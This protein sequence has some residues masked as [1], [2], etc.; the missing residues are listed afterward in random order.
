MEQNTIQQNEVPA[1]PAPMSDYRQP[2]S[3]N[4]TKWIVVFIVLLILGGAGIFFFAQSENESQATPTPSFNVLPIDNE[5]LEDPT[6]TPTPASVDKSEISIEIQNGTGIPGEAAFLQ[7]ELKKLGYSDIEAGN[8][9]STDY[10][11]TVVTFSKSVPEQVQTSLKQELEKI[12]KSVT[13][14]T[15][16]SQTSSVLIITGPRKATSSSTPKATSS[17]TPKATSSAT[18]KA[19]SSATPN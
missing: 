16:S 7:T 13:V 19:T 5:V 14:K 3:G 12:Y 8:A 18:P 9:S 6:S 10:T 17:A 1:T 4:N 2:S 15:S 11:E